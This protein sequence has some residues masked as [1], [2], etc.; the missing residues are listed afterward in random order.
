MT[1]M[2]ASIPH[3][4]QARILKRPKRLRAY[5]DGTELDGIEDLP[6]D[7]DREGKYR[8]APKGYSSGGKI[9]RKDSG[10]GRENLETINGK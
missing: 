5:G 3:P 4:P 10:A 9:V 7:R 8:V 6:T 1:S 2:T